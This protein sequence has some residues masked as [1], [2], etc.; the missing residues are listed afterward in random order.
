[1][2][3]AYFIDTNILVPY[4][5]A[6]ELARQLERRYGLLRPSNR[7]Y[8]SAVTL[9]EIEALIYRFGWGEK[10]R[11]IIGQVTEKLITQPVFRYPLIDRYAE[12]DAY[13]TN[14]HPDLDLGGSDRKMK[15]NDLWI[16][17]TASLLD[18]PLLSMD[19]D[20]EHLNGVFLD[21][22]YIDQDATNS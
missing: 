21:F 10:K 7:C 12:I 16:A 4:V 15:K 14:D 2:P 5:R 17:A 18:L 8:I 20:F 11:D 1:M 19:D 22:I 13:S 6:N 9:G 3:D